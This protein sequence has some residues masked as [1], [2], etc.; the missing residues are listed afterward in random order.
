L[1]GSRLPD[2]A[3]GAFTSVILCSAIAVGIGSTAA[4]VPILGL[5]AP[6]GYVAV[7]PLSFHNYD[8]VLYPLVTLTVFRKVWGKRKAL[9]ALLLVWGLNELV[10]NILYP[11]LDPRDW[12]VW[13]QLANRAYLVGMAAFAVIG[14][15]L[16]RPRLRLHPL[17][18]VFPTYL[19]IWA[20]AGAPLIEVLQLPI[21]FQNWPWEVGYQLALLTS[22]LAAVRPKT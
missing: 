15:V 17:V 16:L 4:L 13:T 12:V 10:F 7:G 14:F 6:F 2:D 21:H 3:V 20:I 1:R 22:F 11:L 9:G 19:A 18:L 5:Y 8:V